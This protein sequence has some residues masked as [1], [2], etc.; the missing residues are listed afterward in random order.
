M[1]WTPLDAAGA[2]LCLDPL[3]FFGKN[4]GDAVAN[5]RVHQNNSDAVPAE[6]STDKHCGHICVPFDDI[7]DELRASV[8]WSPEQ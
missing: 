4:D 7:I 1:D 2:T 5:Y 6:S 8:A 3:L